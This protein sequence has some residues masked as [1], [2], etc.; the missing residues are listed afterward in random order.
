MEIVGRERDVKIDGTCSLRI[1]MDD[2]PVWDM[3][4]LALDDDDRE[5][6]SNIDTEEHIDEADDEDSV[7]D[8][9]VLFIPTGDAEEAEDVGRFTTSV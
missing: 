4:P 2:I 1:D 6:R 8:K 5:S 3:T 9:T 7:G